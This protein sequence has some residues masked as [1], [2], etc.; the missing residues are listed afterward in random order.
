MLR[1]SRMS[2]K[3]TNARTAN[4]RI[5]DRGM[6]R[7][8]V[9][10]THATARQLIVAAPREPRKRDAPAYRIMR[11]TQKNWLQRLRVDP[12]SRKIIAGTRNAERAHDSGTVACCW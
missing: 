5:R 2:G 4:S 1:V 11:V 10:N 6:R 12:A 8:L 3:T 9:S 7:T